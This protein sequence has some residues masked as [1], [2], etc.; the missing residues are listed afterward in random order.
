MSIFGV[1]MWP[2]SVHNQSAK[3]V[4]SR[5]A[6]MGVTDIFFLTKGL[7]G[8]AA[9]QSALVPPFCE[10]D[11]LREL[12]DAAH[13]A[14]IRVHAWLTSASDAHYK[15]LHPESGRVHITRGADKGLISLTDKGYL[16]YMQRVVTE[17]CTGYDIDGL[18]LDYI[19]YNHLLYG[20]SEDDCARYAA[21]G[22]NVPHL[23]TLMER[24]FLSKENNEPHCIFDAFRAGDR[25]ALALAAVRRQDVVH[26]A[27]ALTGTARAVC[28]D[29]P[30]SAALMPEGAYEDTAFSDLHYGQNYEDAARLYDFV[31]PM[32][33]SQAY[34]QDSAWVR[35]VAEGT[36]KHGLKTVMGLHA[37]EG[38]TGATLKADLAALEGAPIEGVCLFREGAFVQAYME[39]NRLHLINSLDVP[40][41][42]AYTDNDCPLPLEHSPLLPGEE[43]SF[44]LA[45]RPDLLRVFADNKEV[46]VYLFP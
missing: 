8:T 32:A 20:W 33:Y 37:Y 19:R 42:Q 18:H 43:R 14:N 1:W 15:A 13:T 4:V 45:A 6:R 11:L 46:S 31:L 12:L 22:A 24:T 23:R 21:A 3:T 38:G 28:P 44:A 5:C 35:R 41:T 30:L 27:Q 2:Q 26:F 25:S 36:H 40:L 39:D 7:A 16:A 17:L 34:T 10:R 9:Y 29:L